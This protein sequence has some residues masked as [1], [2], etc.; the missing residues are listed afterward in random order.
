VLDGHLFGETP[1]EVNLAELL[2]NAQREFK[3][4]K[5]MDE[6]DL[7]QDWPRLR[8]ALGEAFLEWTCELKI[9]TGSWKLRSSPQP[10]LPKSKL[11]PSAIFHFGNSGSSGDRS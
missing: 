7:E 1:E 3:E 10:L 8:A 9:E 5:T 4:V 6:D 2:R 11:R